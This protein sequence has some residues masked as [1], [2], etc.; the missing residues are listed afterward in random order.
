MRRNEGWLALSGLNLGGL[1][2]GLS[3]LLRPCLSAGSSQVGLMNHLSLGS[4]SSSLPAYASPG[5][6]LWCSARQSQAPQ[7][8]AN[9]N[10]PG[11]MGSPHEKQKNGAKN[12]QPLCLMWNGSPSDWTKPEPLHS[13]QTSR[14]VNN[15]PSPSHGSQSLFIGR[16]G[17]MVLFNRHRQTPIC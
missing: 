7:F 12:T 6:A 9:M 3:R 14:L 1:V 17:S 8:L 13:G 11:V 10:C 16:S 2:L 5:I 15:R 4:T